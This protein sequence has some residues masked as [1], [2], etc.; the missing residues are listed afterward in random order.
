MPPGVQ[1]TTQEL[2]EAI[3]SLANGKAVG[4]D[5]VSIRL[6]NITLNGDP[7]LRRRLLDFVVRVWRG[8]RCRSSGKM[9]SSWYST[10]RR[11]RQECGNYRGSTRPF[12]RAIEY[13]LGHA[14]ILRWH[15]RLDDRACSRW[16]AV[17]QDLRQGYVL[18]P[19]LRNISF[20][21]VINVASTRFKADKG[22]MDALVHLRKK[23]GAGRRG[24]AIA[25]E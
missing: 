20:A 19:L 8:A 1:P 4:P 17:E 25:G 24:G 12:W 7:A 16:F 14:S 11:I 9:P 23:R 5:G 2:K 22:I 21:A 18:A 10:K 6:F 15:A 13:D 3:G